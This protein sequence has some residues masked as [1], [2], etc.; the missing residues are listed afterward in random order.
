MLKLPKL[1]E[2]IGIDEKFLIVD[3]HGIRPT[4]NAPKWVKKELERYE[5]ESRLA[6]E[7]EE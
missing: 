5:E 2:D 7:E 4:K 3:E 6:E 1:Y